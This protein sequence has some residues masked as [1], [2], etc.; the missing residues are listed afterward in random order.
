M[1]ADQMT[2]V[3]RIP[4]GDSSDEKSLFGTGENPLPWRPADTQGTR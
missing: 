3:V 2:G 1:L 4:G